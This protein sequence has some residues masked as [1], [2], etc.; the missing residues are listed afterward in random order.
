MVLRMLVS[1][2]VT[3]G[4]TPAA[5]RAISALPMVSRQ[6]WDCGIGKYWARQDI[7]MPANSKSSLAPIVTTTIFT[8]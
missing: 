2:A 6:P 1:A 7:M 5:R 4:L 8:S 3:L